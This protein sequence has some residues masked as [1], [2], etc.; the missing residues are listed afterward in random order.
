M[1]IVSR[2]PGLLGMS[3]ALCLLT[4]WAPRAAAKAFRVQGARGFTMKMSFNGE[5]RDAIVHVPKVKPGQKLRVILNYHGFASNAEQQAKYTRMAELGT[6]AGFIVVH[7]NARKGEG[8]GL[9]GMPAIKMR[10]W[11]GINNRYIDMFEK[12]D[13]AGF[14][15]SL[16]RGLEGQIRS[17]T[18]LRVEVDTKVVFATGLSNG[19]F[20]THLLAR[21]LPEIKAIAPV[22]GQL[23][24]KGKPHRLE[25]ILP[26]PDHKVAMLEVHGTGDPLVH[27]RGRQ[28]E[29]SAK[30]GFG[31]Q[32]VSVLRTARIMARSNGLP[33]RP[34][35]VE[36]PAKSLTV[37]TWGKDPRDLVKLITVK[38]GGHSVPGTNIN[39][40]VPIGGGLMDRKLM[41]TNQDLNAPRAIVDFFQQ[42]SAAYPSR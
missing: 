6:R 16:V 38:G 24:A 28:G 8:I 39:E 2:A 3:L 40:L 11:D 21:R 35:R 20:L 7:P 26:A 42:V 12:N 23:A 37:R 5:T 34:T 15:R 22:A 29:M 31:V 14:T 27:Y 36:H 4:S 41:K 13:D 18:G 9:P 17:K 10:S 30:G 19:A 33:A 32:D 1:N 25:P